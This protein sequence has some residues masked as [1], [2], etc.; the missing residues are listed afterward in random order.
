MLVPYLDPSDWSFDP[1]DPMCQGE[2]YAAVQHYV[3]Q[4]FEGRGEVVERMFAVTSLSMDGFDVIEAYTAGQFE[5]NG[6]QAQR[7]AITFED[8]A[9]SQRQIDAVRRYRAAP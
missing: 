7:G 2:V 9:N 5:L 8:F 1:S 3:G 6:R 4:H